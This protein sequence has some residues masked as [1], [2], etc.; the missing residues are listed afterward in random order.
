MMGKEMQ[1]VRQVFVDLIRDKNRTRIMV[2]AISIFA[3]IMVLA[4]LSVVLIIY[5]DA[6][7][8]MYSID[9]IGNVSEHKK[10]KAS[11]ELAHEVKLHSSYWFS[12]YYTFDHG[13]MPQKRHAAIPLIDEPDYI[14]LEQKW[15]DW[16]Q[17][18]TSEGLSQEAIL[19]EESVR[20]KPLGNE[21]TL[22]Q[23][24]ALFSVTNANFMNTYELQ[25]TTKARRVARVFDGNPLDGAEANPHG[26][27]F[28]DYSDQLIPKERNIPLT[29]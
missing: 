15:E 12:T 29:Q 18:V 22:I 13:N 25:F 3:T 7:E 14:Q 19:I 21:I 10:V 6:T 27:R 24:K 11:F 28:Y 26:F 9:K 17:S 16:F 1:Q 4:A 8:T 5:F 23:A 2:Y 20:Y